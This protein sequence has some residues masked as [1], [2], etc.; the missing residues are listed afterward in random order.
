MKSNSGSWKDSLPP[1]RTICDLLSTLLANSGY[2][3][4]P[5]IR[6][7]T[8]EFSETVRF[9]PKHLRVW[10]QQVS[11]HDSE[12]CTLWLKPSNQKLPPGSPLKNTCQSCRLL[13]RSLVAIRGRAL[14]ASPGHKE[15]WTDPSSNRPVKYLSPAS[16]MKRTV[17]CNEK[18][19]KVRLSPL[20]PALPLTCL[21]PLSLPPSRTLMH[22]KYLSPYC[23]I[24]LHRCGELW[25]RSVT[26]MMYNW[27]T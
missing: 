9:K 18:L 25:C 15:R 21:P 22:H 11:R 6:D 3:L 4:C 23:L 13:H 8:G 16:Q 24:S 5:G 20:P 2:V 19:R 12:E 10:T 7:F 27:A 17:K 1:H 26:H 14:E